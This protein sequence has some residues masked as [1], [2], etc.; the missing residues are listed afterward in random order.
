MRCK[1]VGERGGDLPERFERGEE[2]GGRSVER[3]FG[4]ELGDHL[5]NGRVILEKGM[6]EV[7]GMAGGEEGGWGEVGEDGL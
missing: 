7:K 3:L 4:D 1:L 2:A 5:L 6:E